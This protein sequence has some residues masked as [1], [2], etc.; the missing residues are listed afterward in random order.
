M[1]ASSTVNEKRK[2]SGINVT[3][4]FTLLLFGF[5][6]IVDQLFGVGFSRNPGQTKVENENQSSEVAGT[7]YYN[8]ITSPGECDIQNIG[9]SSIRKMS[10][11]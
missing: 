7:D 10:N 5:A 2:F 11:P 6:Y 4:F 9:Y 8:D 1:L 3:Y